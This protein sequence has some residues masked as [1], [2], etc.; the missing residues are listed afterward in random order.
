MKKN[1]YIVLKGDRRLDITDFHAK[2]DGTLVF[3]TNEGTFCEE[4]APC[5]WV[6]EIE[7]VEPTTTKK[8][9]VACHKFGVIE[10]RQFHAFNGTRHLNKFQSIAENFHSGYLLGKDLQP[11]RDIAEAFVLEYQFVDDS[12]YRGCNHGT[13]A[14]GGMMCSLLELEKAEQFLLSHPEPRKP[15]S[16]STRLSTYEKYGGRCAYCGRQIVD[17]KEMQVDHLVS[18]MFN[19]GEDTLEN[20]MPAC[21]I[22]NRVKSA[23]TLEEFRQRIHRCGEIHRNRKTPINADSDKIARFYGL[24]EEDR[25]VTFLFEKGAK[26]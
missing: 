19:G 16:K 22:C 9:V 17:I 6:T 13:V 5:Y 15:I 1:G 18:H 20:Y 4:D 11:T 26:R 3:E 7:R 21:E 8:Y 2:E 23:Y 10:E 24:T 14:I 12:R 25:D